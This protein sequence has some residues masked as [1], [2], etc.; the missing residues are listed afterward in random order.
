MSEEIKTNSPDELNLGNPEQLGTA[1]D[2]LR[3][4]TA[5]ALDD[6]AYGTDLADAEWRKDMGLEGAEGANFIVQNSRKKYRAD[7]VREVQ[8]L[9]TMEAMQ[10]WGHEVVLRD[11]QSD[12][13]QIDSGWVNDAIRKD[14][15]REPEAPQPRLAPRITELLQLTRHQL[16]NVAYG[17]SSSDYDRK[18][19]LE[20]LRF[21]EN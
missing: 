12:A 11:M 21:A 4:A 3:S 1:V 18:A 17:P 13:P 6:A 19:A 5:A 9:D 7:L 10:Q 8:R 15:Q 2:A 20:A 16:I 14:L